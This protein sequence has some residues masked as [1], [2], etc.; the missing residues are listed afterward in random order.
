VKFFIDTANVEHIREAASWGIV[1]G[2]T[3]NP[4]LV[5]KEGRDFREVVLEIVKIVDGPVSAEVVTLKAETMIEEARELASWHPNIVVKVPLTV[6]GIK[7]TSVLSKE[8]IRTNVTLCFT[9]AQALLVAKAG[10]T[11]VSPFL[12]RLDDVSTDGMALVRDIVEIY[13]M[14]GYAT[15]IIAASCRHPLHI[16]EAAKAGCHIA[17]IPYDV[18]RRLFNHPLTDAGVER[19]LKDWEG[20]QTALKG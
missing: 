7:A 19:F 11:Y 10:G 12:G 3:T 18:M 6:E 1:D 2:V 15:E 9:P 16:V 14:Y 4:S 8:G 5:A 17:T 13:D 20:L